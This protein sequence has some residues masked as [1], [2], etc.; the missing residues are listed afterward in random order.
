MSSKI[1]KVFISSTFEDLIEERKKIIEG[2]LLNKCMP[3][4]MEYFESSDEKSTDLI[5]R[6]MSD[7]DY[8]VL[9]IKGK[10]GS[11]DPVSGKSYTEL[12]YEHALKINIPTLAFLYYD[13]QQLKVKEIE[14]DNE[15][16]QKLISF[17][18]RVK[19]AHTIRKWSDESTLQSLISDSLNQKIN[20]APSGGFVK[21]VY[22][23][24][25]KS[26]IIPFHKI[27]VQEKKT[28][29]IQFLHLANLTC[30][31]PKDGAL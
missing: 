12:E 15:R 14:L 20:L 16:M 8:Y 27:A 4:A 21:E 30:G 18:E 24:N 26:M 19:A 1:Y 22:D 7:C 9:I 2:L 17:Q 25:A 5:E 13:L 23:G 6:L 10:Y 31:K 11:I 3:V 28:V 29:Y